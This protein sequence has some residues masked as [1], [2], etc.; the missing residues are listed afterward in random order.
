[1]AG[2]DYYRF[3][4]GRTSR[5]PRPFPVDA[6][7]KRAG[8]ALDRDGVLWL[9]HTTAGLFSVRDKSWSGA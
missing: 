4:E 3:Y 6:F 7:D 2:K 5:F 9:N 8:C 1:M